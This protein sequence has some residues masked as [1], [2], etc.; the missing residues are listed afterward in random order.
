MGIIRFYIL[1]LTLSLPNLVCTLHLLKHISVWTE[2]LL[3]FDSRWLSG[4]HV[5]GGWYIGQSVLSAVFSHL[6]CPTLCNPMNCSTPGSSVYR[7]SPGKNT[8]VGI[9]F[10]TPGDLP[11][12]GIELRSPALQADSLPA[13]PPGNGW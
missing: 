9:H 2:H 3:M 7:D 10:P 5:A 8:G 13:E 6:S 11:N 12:P 1:L 4:C